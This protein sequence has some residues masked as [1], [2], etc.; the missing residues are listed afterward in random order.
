MMAMIWS[1]SSESF[2]FQRASALLALNEGVYQ[3]EINIDDPES[4]FEDLL[5]ERKLTSTRML[6]KP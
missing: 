4:G 2:G 3:L 1:V 6:S 5:L